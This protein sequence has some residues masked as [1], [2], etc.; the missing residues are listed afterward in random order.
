MGESS[1]ILNFLEGT[2][3]ECPNCHRIHLERREIDG[4]ATYNPETEPPRIWA[5]FNRRDALDRI[6]LDDP[7]SLA[8]IARQR[9]LNSSIPIIAYN[10]DMEVRGETQFAVDENDN[11]REDIWA[12][13][14][15]DEDYA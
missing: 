14:P 15:D 5:D 12:V 4:I 11:L 8:D 1:G 2:L 7:R 3:T 6:V 9:L 13:A 10:G